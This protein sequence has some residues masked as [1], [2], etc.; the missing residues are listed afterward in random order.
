LSSLRRSRFKNSWNPHHHR[1][2]TEARFSKDLRTLAIKNTLTAKHDVCRKLFQKLKQMAH[3]R[4]LRKFAPPKSHVSK[5]LSL[6]SMSYSS[7][8]I[9]HLPGA[10][11]TKASLGLEP[12]TGSSCLA[13]N[14]RTRQTKKT[15]HGNASRISLVATST[16][17]GETKESSQETRSKVKLVTAG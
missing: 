4:H 6:I 3:N 17:C 12:S 2:L 1:C 14:S 9:R 13:S 5:L 11:Q 10:G 8:G 16:P 7:T 15:F